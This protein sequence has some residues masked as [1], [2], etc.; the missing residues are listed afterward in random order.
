MQ[1]IRNPFSGPSTR[2]LLVKIAIVGGGAAGI[3][4]AYL[5]DTFHQ[6]SLFEK[7][8]ILGGNVRTLNKNVSSVSFSPKFPL[9]NGVIEFLR[10]H[11]P[12]FN[13]LMED[14]GIDL[15]V[16]QGGATSFFSEDG[17]YWQSPG[18]VN[19]DSAPFLSK[20]KDYFK[21]LPLLH[22][23]LITWGKIHLFEKKIFFDQPISKFFSDRLM[24]RWYKMLLMYGYSTPYS[25]IDQFS[26]EIAFELLQ[27][28]N[29]NTQWSRI[30]GG[31]YSYFE[32]I[33]GRFRGKVHCNV[34][35]DNIVRKSNGALLSLKS[36]ETLAFDKIIFATPPDQIPSLLADPTDEEKKRFA[37]W[38][39]NHISTQIHTDTGL[40]RPYG[41]NSYTEF[42]VFEKD[43]GQEGGYNAYLN[44][45]CGLSP[46]HPTS[47]FLAYNLEECIDPQQVLDVQNHQTPLYTPEAIHYRQE[48]RETNGEN[49]TYYTG[50]YLNNGLHEG[51]IASA[52]AVSKMLGR[53]LLS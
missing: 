29:L 38:N 30:P 35:I 37:A 45:L 47:Y 46:R 14:L 40:Y 50:A 43:T 19:Q 3:A 8:P 31:V 33:L 2:T 9:D 17:S 41:I 32:A 18:A 5:L 28:I 6:I 4:T 48:I 36:G 15:E 39:T 51:A 25:K 22:D 21:L 34:Q 27:Q 53:K 16:T 52:A 23:Y 10:D 7:Q 24:S 13:A 20:C 11:S 44:R 26:A 42:D 49:H 1:I 12:Y